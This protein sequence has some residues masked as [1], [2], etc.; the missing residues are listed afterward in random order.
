[1]DALSLSHDVRARKNLSA[2]LQASASVGG[3]AIAKALDVSEATV[4]RMRSDGDL[5]RYCTLL[6]VCGLKVVPITM[7]CYDAE[8]IGAIFVLARRNLER[9]QDPHIELSW[10]DD[11]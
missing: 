4:S 2:V 8:V 6:A 11:E 9:I 1:M 3:V 7:K 10:G 5:E